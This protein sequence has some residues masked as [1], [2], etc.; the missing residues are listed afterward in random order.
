MIRRAV[1]VVLALAFAPVP[2]H[3]QDLAITV[4]APS[5]EIHKGPSTVTPV[6]GHVS[7]GAVLPVSRNLGSW[8]RV[9]WPDAPDG[10]GYLHVT[11][12]RI[13]PAVA[14]SV[15]TDAPR[16]SAAAPAAPAAAQTRGPLDPRLA[17]RRQAPSTPASHVVGIGGLFGSPESFGATARAWNS[18]RIGVQF[19]FARTSLTNN[20]G[21]GR[22]TAVQFEPGVIYGLFDRVSD[23]VWI[24]PYVGS[25]MTI[26]RQTLNSTVAG[27]IAASDT[28]VGFRIFGGSEFTFASL[29][30]FGLSADVGYRR[31]PTSFAGFDTA[32]LGVAVA[33]HW[34]VK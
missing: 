27:A 21:A 4:S 22:V 28:S 24:R 3:A 14:A 13:A 29:P 19:G 2:V 18:H 33:G 5:A 34:Y 7:R 30:R 8:V 9:P 16:Q 11:M 23:Y 26:G 6:V 31:F 10:V 12:G 20:A 25:T 32:P 17:P 15:A 1:P